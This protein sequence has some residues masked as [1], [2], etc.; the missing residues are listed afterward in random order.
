M[1][2]EKLKIEQPFAIKFFEAAL[3]SGNRKFAH[4]YMLEGGDIPAQYN[5]VMQTAKI[6][7]CMNSKILTEGSQ[8]QNDGVCS[9]TNCKWITENKHPAVITISPVD[10]LFG[11]SDGKPKTVI[12]VGQAKYLRQELSKTS[13]YYRVVIFTD[14]AEGKEN[15]RNSETM[16]QNCGEAFSPP[17][18]NMEDKERLDWS[19][20]PLTGKILQ[21]ESADALL[22]II[23]EPPLNIVFFFLTKDKQDLP[24]TIVSRTQV[25]PVVST[26]RETRDLSMLEKFFGVFP[27]KNAYESVIYTDRL[28]E[29]AKEN[30]LSENDLL[31]MLQEYM[32][33]L[34]KENVDNEIVAR[35]IIQNIRRIREAQTE[36]KNHVNKQAVLESVMSS[37]V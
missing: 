27:P 35:K 26:C 32:R 29:I 14:A 28:L 1:Y 9:C 30:S 23:E 13:Q 36:I 31:G 10:Y 25:L 16:R 5:I 18:L 34:L 24:E 21:S 2:S 8:P 17:S 12:T 11:N 33:R 4:A 15:E 20:L 6:L 3:R 19:L 22:K 7:N 37:F